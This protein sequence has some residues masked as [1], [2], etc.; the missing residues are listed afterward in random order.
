MQIGALFVGLVLVYFVARALPGT[1]TAILRFEAVMSAVGASVRRAVGRLVVNEGSLSARYA[2]CE[3]DRA[4]LTSELIEQAAVQSE[5][6][7][8]RTLVGYTERSGESGIP[9]RIVRRSVDGNATQVT[10]DRGTEDGVQSGAA[11][12]VGDGLFFGT[13]VSATAQTSVVELVT[14]VQ[15]SVPS[16]LLSKESTIG[17]VQGREGALLSLEFIPQES[18]IVTGDIIATSGLEGRYP[19]GLALGI[20]TDVTTDARTPFK[21][22]FV[23]MLYDPLA[24]THVFIMR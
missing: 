13:I 5:I 11:V 15:S 12:I 10:L 18:D 20:V 21:R 16:S 17:V 4:E 23:E 1:S 6:D 24:Q 19:E 3:A 22:A 8:W 2:A 7:Q 9:A 14:S